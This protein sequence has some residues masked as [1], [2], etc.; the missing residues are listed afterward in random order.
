M[1]GIVAG[2][3]AGGL[4]AASW[5][6]TAAE[7]PFKKHDES[8]K[9]ASRTGP[10]ENQRS[11]P[12]PSSGLP[13]PLPA[14]PPASEGDYIL[15]PKDQV[16][17]QVFGQEDLTRTVRIDQ[18]GNIVLPMIGAV[19]V[20]GGTVV[21]AQQKIESALKQGGFLLNP[22]VTVSVSEYQGRQYAVVG[23]VNQPGTYTLKTRQTPLL[24]AISEARG[25][26]ENAE[27]AAY[28]VRAKP[29]PGEAQPLQVDLVT[30]VK[31]GDTNS[32]M[33]EPGDVVYVPEENTF[34][35]TGEVE[36][37]GAFTLKRDT[38]LSKAITEAGGATKRAASDRVTVV[39]TLPSGEKKEITGI[40]LDAVMKG[41]HKADVKLQAQDVVVVPA[42]GAKVAGYNIL[43][44]LRGVFSIGAS[45]PLR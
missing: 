25:V 8:D 21:E 35:V 1:R 29:H 28:V 39:R 27:P 9:P 12:M 30:M 7:V 45:V 14:A 10:A 2:I 19:P 40:N 42:D 38:T 34:Y 15:A 4:L 44:F 18:D 43:D 16:L 3:V 36:K 37:R 32:V 11:A 22:R 20:A 17:V 6:A 41:D 23:A 5:C 33:I 31:S 24:T 26:R 13:G